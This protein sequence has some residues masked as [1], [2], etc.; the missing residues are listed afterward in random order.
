[1]NARVDRDIGRLAELAGTV[2]VVDDDEAVRDSLLM[3]LAAEGFSTTG[4]D[5]C[6]AALAAIT[7]QSPDCVVLDLHFP[8]MSGAE[9]IRVLT[10]RRTAVPVVM[11]T[12]HIDRKSRLAAT[13]SGAD[14]V[15]Q[16]P[17]VPAELIA[18]V[19]RACDRPAT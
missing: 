13:T 10:A 15:L 11:I 1:M 17:L 12:G 19:H 3:V 14:V 6:P 4:F 2:F 5:N 7:S 8:G 16:K 18:A 9:L